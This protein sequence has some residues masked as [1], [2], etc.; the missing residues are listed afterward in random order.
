MEREAEKSN[1][2]MSLGE[3]EN[4]FVELLMNLCHFLL[5]I[6]ATQILPALIPPFLHPCSSPQYPVLDSLLCHP[7][8]SPPPSP[9]SRTTWRTVYPSK[10]TSSLMW[11][12]SSLGQ[13]RCTPITTWVSSQ[14]RAWGLRV[15]RIYKFG[16]WG[17]RVLWVEDL[18][19]PGF[20]T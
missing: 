16:A 8:D 19:V 11:G 15:P 7:T 9:R 5:P 14:P 6:F 12:L 1:P 4:R 18:G 17:P 3:K 2:A 20:R 10:F 13:S